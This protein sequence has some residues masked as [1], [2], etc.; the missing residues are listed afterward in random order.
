MG[1][2]RGRNPPLLPS[3]EYTQMLKILA[4]PRYFGTAVLAKG[5]IEHIFRSISIM[6]QSLLSQLTD[7][8]TSTAISGVTLND[9]P[10]SLSSTF[11]ASQPH[12][13]SC[14]AKDLQST[15]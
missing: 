8:M 15:I 3:P 5:S 13:S 11:A 2:S 6:A 14:C 10:A 9:L 7:K 12:D 1:Y 4:N